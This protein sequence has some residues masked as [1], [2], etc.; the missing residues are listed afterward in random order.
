MTA[1]AHQMHS[2][3]SSCIAVRDGMMSNCGFLLNRCTL[4]NSLWSCLAYSCLIVG[5]LSNSL[6]GGY[7]LVL[8]SSSLGRPKL[9]LIF[10]FGSWMYSC[11]VFV[12]L[13]SS[14]ILQG[15]CVFW[16]GGCTLLARWYEKT[17]AK[18]NVRTE[19]CFCDVCSE[20]EKTYR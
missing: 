11:L 18:E 1:F 10:A 2:L 9:L 7:S 16:S 3:S 13:V 19:D 14:G 12:R 8:L 15:G 20:D 6:T 4:V 5:L 17:N